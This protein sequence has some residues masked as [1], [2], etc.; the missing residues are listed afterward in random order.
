M[1]VAARAWLEGGG[2]AAGGQRPFAEAERGNW[3]YVPRR[4]LGVT[5]GAMSVPSR[6]RALALLRAGLSTPGARQAEAVMALEEVL[7]GLE[8]SSLRARDPLGYALTIFG[9]PG[10]FPWGWR[11]EGHHLS[12]NVTVA[13]AEHV[14]MTPWFLGTNPA[15]IPRG[16][17]AGERLQGPEQDLAFELARSLDASQWRAALFSVQAPGDVITGPGRAA[18]LARPQGLPYGSLT[19]SQQAVLLRLIE[20]YVGRA[21][22][23][24]GRP[25]LELVRSGL[26]HTHVAWAGGREPGTP[27][28]YRIHGPRL[29]IEL[30]NTQNRANHVHSLWRD[31]LNDF[32]RDDLRA[33]YASAAHGDLAGR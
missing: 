32:G 27:F 19:A 28:Y 12:L 5:L 31:P 33:H 17:R 13:S 2:A 4:R 15:R 23:A 25:Y 10:S 9:T 30:D 26:A 8:G 29:L 1:A 24:F 16:P 3:H 11:L 21:H 7:A 20:V 22:D 6:E 14:A 18:S